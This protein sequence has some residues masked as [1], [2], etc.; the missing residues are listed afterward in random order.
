M[1]A[2][3]DYIRQ[4]IGYFATDNIGVCKLTEDTGEYDIEI[5]KVEFF[6]AAVRISYFSDGR[7]ETFFY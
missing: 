1:F 4:Q 2:I 6:G 5:A 3:N 7:V